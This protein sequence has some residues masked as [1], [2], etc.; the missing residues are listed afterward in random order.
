MIK[1]WKLNDD[2]QLILLN[3]VEFLKQEI[4]VKNTLIEC[5]ITEL[6]NDRSNASTSTEST[7]T[8]SQSLYDSNNRDDIFNLRENIQQ[9]KSK[10]VDKSKSSSPFTIHTNSYQVLDSNTS[11]ETEFEKAKIVSK[12]LTKQC[13]MGAEDQVMS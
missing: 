2:T 3:Q 12:H 5:L 8:L 6:F 7:N 11:F 1:E 13:I 9:P 10:I 4:A